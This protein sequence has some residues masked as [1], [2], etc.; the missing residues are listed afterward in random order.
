MMH[1]T[2]LGYVPCHVPCRL[3]E[4]PVISLNRAR[5]KIMGNID[6]WTIIQSIC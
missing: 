5:L 1:A 6:K 4:I 2:Y 3:Q